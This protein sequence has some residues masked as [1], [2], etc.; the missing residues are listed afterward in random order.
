MIICCDI[1]RKRT[2][3]VAMKYFAITVYEVAGRLLYLS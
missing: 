3:E 1:E 2:A